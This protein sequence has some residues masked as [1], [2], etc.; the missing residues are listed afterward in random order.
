MG[1]I[2]LPQPV[3]PND[4]TSASR[5]SRGRAQFVTTF[6]AHFVHFSHLRRPVNR[7][8]NRSKQP[9]RQSKKGQRPALLEPIF[10]GRRRWYL[11]RHSLLFSTDRR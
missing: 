6:R 8:C 2:L 7:N 3:Q 1:G 9:R 11:K 5:A 10:F 4:S